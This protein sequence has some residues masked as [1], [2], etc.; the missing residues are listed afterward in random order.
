MSAE[1]AVSGFEIH[2]EA[3]D[4]SSDDQLIELWLHE[5]SPHTQRAYQADV[6]RFRSW[7]GKPLRTVTLSDLQGFANISSNDTLRPIMNDYEPAETEVGTLCCMRASTS[8]SLLHVRC[9]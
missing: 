9:S 2:P 6:R 8:V 5:R 4:G 7:A 1:I 3:P